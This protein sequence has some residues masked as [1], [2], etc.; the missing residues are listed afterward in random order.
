VRSLAQPGLPLPKARLVINGRFLS[1]PTTGVQR[2][3]IEV[4]V[5]M[6]RLISAETTVWRPQVEIV[7]PPDAKLASLRLG[8]IEVRRYGKRKG[9][10]W[11]QLDLAHY[12]RRDL[13]LSLAN[14]APLLHRRQIVALHDAATRAVPQSYSWRFRAWYRLMHGRASRHARHLVT[15]SAFS[16]QQLERYYGVARTRMTIAP[17]ASSHMA[18][19]TPQP[20]ILVNNRL[21]RDAYVFAFGSHNPSKN[22]ALVEE[23]LKLMSEPRPLL[24]MAGRSNA[25]VF[26][27]PAAGPAHHVLRVGEVTDEELKALYENALCFIF[28]SL[29]EGFGIPAIEAMACQCPVIAARAAALPEV[30]GSAALYCDPWDPA[31]LADNIRSLQGDPALRDEMRRRGNARVREFSWAVSAS[32]ILELVSSEL[33]CPAEAGHASQP[34]R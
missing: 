5:A 34:A 1:Q 19:V 33:A 16:A 18:N 24:V 10:L 15:V 28:P 9:V 29:Y 12:A 22:A 11:E 23:A 27:P 13:L 21:V 8:A 4:V 20:Q 14:S 17:N 2:Y 30:C 3:A 25:M 7:V 32:R 26:K 6:D 31:G